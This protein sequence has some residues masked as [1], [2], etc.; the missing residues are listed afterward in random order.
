MRILFTNNTLDKPAGTEL[1]VF[2][3]ARLL[4]ARG[5]EVVAYS[6]QQG[7]VAERLTKEGVEVIVNLQCSIDTGETPGGVPWKPDVIHGHH[8]WE[9]S[10]AAL[11]F[12]EVPV[13]SFRRGTAP[14]QEAP[15]RAPNVKRWVA[16]DAVCAKSLIDEFEIFESQ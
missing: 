4:K 1:S 13:I 2:D 12:P 10:L 9:T 5:H 11:A 15:C 3:Y 7:E 14:W 8:E 6:R 16:V